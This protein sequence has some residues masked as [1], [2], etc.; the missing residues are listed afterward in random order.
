MAQI[1]NTGN[2]QAVVVPSGTPTPALPLG[3]TT[4]TTTSTY[5]VPAGKKATIISAWCCNVGSS[6]YVQINASNNRVVFANTSN[7]S[8]SWSG[9]I[10]LSAGEYAKLQGYGGFTYYEEDI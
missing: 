3:A 6:A 5:T 1:I 8:D 4:R 9:A 10:V 7:T 2:T